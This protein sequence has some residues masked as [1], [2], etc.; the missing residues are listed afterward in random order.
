MYLK[1]T[2]NHYILFI[3]QIKTLELFSIFAFH[4]WCFNMKIRYSVI[5]RLN[6][7]SD[8]NL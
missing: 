2:Y 3:Y 5:W 7:Y 1:K 8:K 4:F 6:R